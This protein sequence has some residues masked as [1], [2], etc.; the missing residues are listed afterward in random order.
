MSLSPRRVTNTEN[1]PS[2]R[3]QSAISAKYSSSAPSSAV[4]RSRYSTRLALRWRSMQPRF[5]NSHSA[6]CIT[7]EVCMS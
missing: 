1:P 3:G 5:R 2:V 6:A 4:M 7:V